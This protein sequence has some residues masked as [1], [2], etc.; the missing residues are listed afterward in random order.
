VTSPTPGAPEPCGGTERGEPEIVVLDDA[1]ALGQE[2]AERV[3]AGLLAAIADRGVAHFAVTGGASPIAL[4]RVL[5]G[6][7]D[8]PWAAVHLWWGDDRFVPPDHPDSNVALVRDTLLR[9][10]A[11]TVHGAAIP[12]AN[13]HPV[14]ILAGLQAGHA[15]ERVAAAYAEEILRH[16]PSPGGRPMFDVMLLG[17]GPDGHVM[18]AFPG[19]PAVAPNAPLALA[20]PA[21]Q[22]VGPHLPR[23][24]LRAHVADDARVL[25]VLIPD[26]GKAAIAARALQGELDVTSV[27]A[28]VARR[29]GATWLLTTAAAAQLRE[30]A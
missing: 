26:G 23:I 18:S 10:N 14:P 27:P 9:A 6:R 29:G 12:A 16:V 13:V 5:A 4:Y 25:L 15:A 2:A 11:E 17:V 24:T 3:V 20:V 22:E 7:T 21:P 28:Q 19:S 30:R 8:I 1:T